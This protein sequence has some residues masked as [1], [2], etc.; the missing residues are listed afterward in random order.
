MIAPIPEVGIILVK[1][2]TIS[3]RFVAAARFGVSDNGD[4]LSPRKHPDTMAPAAIGS[5]TPRPEAMP[6]SAIPSYE[7]I[8]Q[9]EPVTIEAI[10][11]SKKAENK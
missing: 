1:I 11:Q 4:H 8:A 10:A 2:W 6:I 3:R 5:G 9:L 7:T